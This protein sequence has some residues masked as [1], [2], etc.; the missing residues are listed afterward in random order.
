MSERDVEGSEVPSTRGCLLKQDLW[1]GRVNGKLAN[2]DS[3]GR[4]AVKPACVFVYIFIAVY[5]INFKSDGQRY[6]NNLHKVLA[7]HLMD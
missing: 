6:V 7:L 5:G 1:R 3:P 4:I 2:A